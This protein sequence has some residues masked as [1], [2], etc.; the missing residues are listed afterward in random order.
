VGTLAPETGLGPASQTT[1]CSYG[2]D[3][4]ACIHPI[5]V[6][7]AHTSA[8]EKGRPSSCKHGTAAALCTYTSSP[9]PQ[10]D[11]NPKNRRASCAPPHHTH[12]VSA[13]LLPHNKCTAS[14]YLPHCHYPDASQLMPTACSALLLNTAALLLDTAAG[15][16]Q[17]S[18]TYCVLPLPAAH[19]PALRC[20]GR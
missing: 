8:Q 11:S 18:T 5:G 19:V 2:R 14:C 13:C 15:L 12:S 1:G 20:T 6:S 17:Q 10:H 9:C 3:Q 16:P 7:E 4:A